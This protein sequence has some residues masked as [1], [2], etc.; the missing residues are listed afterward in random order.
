MNKRR[1]IG[2]ALTVVSLVTLAWSVYALTAELLVP[3][4]GF[5]ADIGL[6]SDEQCTAP[7]T[8]ID[9]GTIEPGGSVD[10]IVY[11]KNFG[12]EALNVTITPENWV[13][14]DA[15]DYMT[16]SWVGDDEIEASAVLGYTFTLTVHPNAT[17]Q[18]IGDFDFDISILGS[19]E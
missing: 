5:I 13:P 17:G 19:N 8:T 6:F 1:I 16:L 4:G 2:L 14:L 15:S 12:G 18:E 9:W 7:K 11:L 10:K 3:T